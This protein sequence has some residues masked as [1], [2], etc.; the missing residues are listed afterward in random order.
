MKKIKYEKAPPERQPKYVW[1]EIEPDGK[2]VKCGHC[3]QY[4]K[5][6]DCVYITSDMYKDTISGKACIG[7]DF[8]DSNPKGK[9]VKKRSPARI[10]HTRKPV[11]RLVKPKSKK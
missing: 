4:H 9:T 3:G 1:F 5:V 8:L 11:L 6:E 10:W 7:Q 2:P